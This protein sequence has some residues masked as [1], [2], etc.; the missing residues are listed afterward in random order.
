MA[1]IKAKKAQPSDVSPSSNLGCK[2]SDTEITGEYAW[3]ITG[4]GINFNGI[5]NHF[6]KT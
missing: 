5:K 4:N 3:V 2:Y 1:V 6:L